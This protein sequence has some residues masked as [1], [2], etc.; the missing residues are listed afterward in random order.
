[1]AVYG[2]TADFDAGLDPIVRVDA[3]RLRDKLREYY[4]SAPHDAII[5]SVPKGSYAPTFETNGHATPAVVDAIRPAPTF[6]SRVWS[7]RGALVLL[8]VCASLALA[9]GWR[10][11]ASEAAVA[12]NSHRDVVS[13][14]GRDAEPVARWQFRRVHLERHR[15]DRG[16]PTCG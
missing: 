14:R 9:I 12:A 7:V 16:L 15:F 8:A 11:V 4:A 13:R 6:Q 2:K 3:R 1:M 10:S 5:I